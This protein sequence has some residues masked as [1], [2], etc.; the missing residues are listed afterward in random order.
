MHLKLGGLTVPANVSAIRSKIHKIWQ[1]GRVYFGYCCGE[2]DVE[3]VCFDETVLNIHLGCRAGGSET[4][5]RMERLIKGTLQ[6]TALY[7]TSYLVTV[8]HHLLTDRPG[9]YAFAVW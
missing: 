4:C 1:C 3:N 5:A 6:E 2:E 7:S 9:R 8:H